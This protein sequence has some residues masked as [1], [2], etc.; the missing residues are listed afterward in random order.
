MNTFYL[1]ALFFFLNAKV[2]VVFASARRSAPER[3]SYFET[4]TE[5][6]VK[7]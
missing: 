7:K 2:F 3:S 5:E 4:T 1:K 6:T